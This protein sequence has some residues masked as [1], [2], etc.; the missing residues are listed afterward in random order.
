MVIAVI[1]MTKTNSKLGRL[2]LS[3]Q[4][5]D[6]GSI[7][8]PAERINMA[9]AAEMLL[10]ENW[11]YAAL[12][13]FEKLG[14]KSG[15]MK[16]IRAADDNEDIVT[17]RQA[18]VSYIGSEACLQT[19]DLFYKWSREQG[20]QNGYAFQLP[21]VLN[22][23][24]HLAPKYSRGVAIAK[25][26]L[27]SGYIFN[28]FGLEVKIADSHRQGTSASFGWMTPASWE[29]FENQDIVVFDKDVDT[30]RTSARV[31]RELQEYNPRSVDL[32]LNIDPI[33]ERIYLSGGT[34]LSR[35]PPGFRNVYYPCKLNYQ[36]FD[37]AVRSLTEKI[38]LTS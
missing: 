12:K 15:V 33:D 4:I 30:G 22:M 8:T 34:M 23:A 28:L 29:E 37:K 9:T 5:I 3:K 14:S 24:S 32:V 31:L 18:T 17:L 7:T 1:Y 27:Y 16:V 25:G 21:Q 19:L 13:G 2:K 38:G 26:G 6:S 36:S 35:V 10:G 20:F 11:L